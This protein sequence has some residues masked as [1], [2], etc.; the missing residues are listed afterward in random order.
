VRNGRGVKGSEGHDKGIGVI[1]AS[2]GS[3]IPEIDPL[4]RNGCGDVKTRLRLVLQRSFQVA[5]LVEIEPGSARKEWGGVV[6]GDKIAKGSMM[7]RNWGI[8]L[9]PPIV[10]VLSIHM[11]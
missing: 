3:A 6:G 5:S 7:W 8:I 10:L 11:P 1:S 4:K 9:F 2:A